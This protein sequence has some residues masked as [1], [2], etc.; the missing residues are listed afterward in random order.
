MSEE[1][2]FELVWSKQIKELQGVANLYRYIK[3]GAEVL[4]IENS[5]ENKVFGITFRTPPKD[6]TGVAHI[7]EHSV[8]CGSQKYP[9]K[10]P[11]V[12][13]LKGSLQTFLNA[14]TFPDKTCYPVASQNVQDLYNL[15]D[16][17]LDAV[18]YPLITRDVFEQEGWHLE[19]AQEDKQPDIT[20]VVYNEMKGAYSSPDGLLNEYSQKS[21]FPSTTYSLDSGGNPTSIPYLTYEDFLDFHRN[22]YHPSNARIFVYGDDDPRQRLKKLHEYLKDFEKTEVDSRIGLQPRLTK[23]RRL[24]HYYIADENSESKNMCTLNW[25]LDVTTNV[26]ANLELQVLE[27][28]LIGMPG[29]PLRKALID[30]GLGEDLAGVGLERELRQMFFSTGLKGV[31]EDNLDKVEATVFNTLQKL[32]QDGIDKG[33]IQAA[34]NTVE[35]ELRENN[36]GSL[37]RGLIVMLN[38]LSTWL[39]DNDP[40][41]MLAYEEPLTDLKQRLDSGEPVFEQLINTNFLENRHWSRVDLKPDPELGNK[42]EEAEKSIVR[43][44]LQESA[45]AD[46]RA[47]IERTLELK[48]KQQEP[49]SPEDLA[50]IPRLRIQDLPEKVKQIPLQVIA[51]ENVE[52]LYHNLPTNHILYLD[53]GFDLRMLPQKYL[54]YLPIFGRALLE[55]GTDKEDY[56]GLSKKIQSKTGGIHTETFNA[57]HKYKTDPCSWMFIRG[58]ALNYQ[59][60][61]LLDILQ[62]IL[63]DVQFDDKERFK[64]LLLEEKSRQEHR[65][66]PIG[67]RIVN[68]RLK[69]KYNTVSCINEQMHGLS[70]L[71]F[72][73]YLASEV[74]ENWQNILSDLEHIRSLMLSKPGMLVNVTLD[75]DNWKDCQPRLQNFLQQVPTRQKGA[76]KWQTECMPGYEA[77]QVPSQ[78]NYVGKG[79][80]LYEQGYNFHGS[81]L[82]ITRYLRS[83]WLWDKL[84][85]Q[86]GAYGAFSNLDRYSGVM[87]F[88]SYRDPNLLNTLEN[89]DQ[90]ADF[91]E[92]SELEDEEINKAVLGAVGDMDAYQLPDDQGMTSM[93]RYIVG[94]TEDKR[95][96]LR[97][98]IMNTTKSDF[99]NFGS[100]LQ[101]LRDKGEVVVLGDKSSISRAKEQGVRFGHEWS[102]F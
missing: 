46:K 100:W 65:I 16:V 48:R 17:Y 21:L 60:Q 67:H 14:M 85:V 56:V 20:G 84:R 11:F 43:E 92:N 42:L 26:D 80:N 88:V 54:G 77:I 23:P 95:Q 68:S 64:Q 98:E 55:M 29:S 52:I 75:E 73:R 99:R 6:S 2:G 31:S 25:L 61:D 4:S 37:P 8:L 39:Y 96:E 63:C 3:N 90:T 58:K 27:Y 59:M 13:L 24:E 9:L 83:S 45:N 15:M 94:E 51:G 71:L 41:L 34:M 78:V 33:L 79:M 38:S 86:G 47:L 91:L 5:D 28:I 66:I 50:K 7:L 76:Q 32:V 101:Y 18:F 62:E 1:F 22:Y 35:F 36:T 82:V 44:K 49:D 72:L 10:E 53:L 97:E 57:N 89:Y 102:V 12:E 19:L 93:L 87:S 81:S 30:S 40:T 74:D 70:Q 69:A